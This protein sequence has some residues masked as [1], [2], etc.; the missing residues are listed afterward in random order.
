[1]LKP[2]ASSLLLFVTAL[3]SCYPA[4]CLSSNS[5]FPLLAWLPYISIKAVFLSKMPISSE[6][7]ALFQRALLIEGIE[8]VQREIE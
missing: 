1:M 3:R 4:S 5:L 7:S 8:G 6:V 2:C